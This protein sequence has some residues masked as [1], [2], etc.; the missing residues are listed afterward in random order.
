MSK[1]DIIVIIIAFVALGAVLSA[2]SFGAFGGGVPED[3]LFQ[4]DFSDPSSGW[5]Q[6]QMDEGVTDYANGEYRISVDAQNTD[7]W[8]NPGLDFEDVRIEVEATKVA[9]DDDNDFGVICRYQDNE[10]YYFF[11][12]SSDGYYGIGRVVG[13]NQEI[14]GDGSMLPT[15]IVNQGD[16]TNQL[17][18]D[19]VGDRLILYVNGEMLDEQQDS[20]FSR[21][22]VG[23]LAGTFDTPG[24]EIRFDNFKVLRPESSQ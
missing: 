3:V 5:D 9:G 15:E 1:S 7:I 6:A 20:S 19:C 18:A 12:I 22:D 4:D 17:R 10:N 23:L 16:A 14:I 2:C 24:T 21:G 8:A 11:V 13:G